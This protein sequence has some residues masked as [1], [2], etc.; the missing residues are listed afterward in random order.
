MGTLGGCMLFAPLIWPRYAYPWI[1]GFIVLL[2]EP[3]CYRAGPPQAESLLAQFERGDP[4]PFLR[5]LLA[6]LVCGGLWEFWNFWAY[7]KWVYTVPFFEDL[8]WF[9]M[10]PLGFLGFPPFA[11][12]CYVLVNF[13]NRFRRGRGWGDP[14]QV[15]PGAPRGLAAASVIFACIFNIGVYAGIDHFTVQS[16]SPM[17]AE[18][19]GL[20]ASHLGQLSRVGVTAPHALLR[21]TA[22]VERLE[23]LARLSGIGEADLEVLRMAARLVELK[24]L[25][26]AHYNELRRI[27]ISR[28]EDLA[29]QDPEDLLRR[30]KAAS[31]RRPP[32]LPQVK[33]WVRAARQHVRAS[34]SPHTSRRRSPTA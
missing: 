33:V 29:T 10:P 2:L 16:Y 32:T 28:V 30:W 12:E 15:G 31:A 19:E 34:G 11:L 22:T 4:R 26:A 5:L 24:G 21:Q 13:I 17:L 6:G 8:K 27:G 18:M 23:A 7:T 1:W 14:G 25:G 9:E 3:I 20:P